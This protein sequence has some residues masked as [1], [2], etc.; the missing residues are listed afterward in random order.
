M[1]PWLVVAR[2]VILFREVFVSGLREFLGDTAGTA[3]G[4]NLAKWK[5]TAQMVAIAV[6]FAKGRVRALFRHSLGHGMGRSTAFRLG[7]LTTSASIESW[8]GWPVGL[9]LLWVAAVLTLIRART[10]SAKPCL[11]CGATV[12]DVCILHGSANASA[13]RE[14]RSTQRGDCGGLGRRTASARED[15]YAALCRSSALAGGVDQELADFDAPC[16]RARS[17]VFPANDGRLT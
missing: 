5:T 12:M 11:T 13:C 10:T 2:H 7:L 6:L 4:H 8:N 17:G 16:R 15:R 3:Q 9:V 14:E 1:V